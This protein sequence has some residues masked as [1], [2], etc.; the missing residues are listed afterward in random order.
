MCLR[1]CTHLSILSLFLQLVQPD[2]EFSFQQ[3]LNPANKYKNRYA[4]IVACKLFFYTL[5]AYVFEF[6]LLLV[7]V[8]G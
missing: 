7:F 1:G 8:I 5:I 2:E 6:L 4:N 3:F